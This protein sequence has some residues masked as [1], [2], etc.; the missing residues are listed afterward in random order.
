MD[1]STLI[2]LLALIFVGC[3]MYAYS[4]NKQVVAPEDVVIT[5]PSESSQDVSQQVAT[6][7]AGQ[8]SST[9]IVEALQPHI[10]TYMDSGFSSGSLTIKKGEVV[11]FENK[12][13]RNMWVASAMHPS[14]RGYPGS[15]IEK[16]GTKD[17]ETIFD[18]CKG[19]APNTSWSFTFNEVGTWKYHNHL[20]ARSFGS[21]TV[22]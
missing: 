8:A 19:F 9:A 6:S 17:V 13:S 5:Q 21:I 4:H 11:I 1:K 15:N 2:T 22:E 7:T 18:A 16:C 12:S 10:V 14:H 20:D 3:G